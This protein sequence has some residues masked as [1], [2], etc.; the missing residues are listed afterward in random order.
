MEESKTK[1]LGCLR[2]LPQQFSLK[3]VFQQLY[4]DFMQKYKSIGHMRQVDISDD[5]TSPVFYLP[6]H[7]VRRENNR[8]TK[9]RVVFN[10][11]SRTNN[12]LTFND[13]FQAGE[14]LQTEMSDIFLW[15]HTHRILF[16]TDIVKMFRQIAMH[17]DDWNL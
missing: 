17:P 10:A 2:R 1:A 4:V 13:I 7:G 16:S 8:T 3:L 6:H 12:G 5:Q 14:K 9:L 15:I 11:S